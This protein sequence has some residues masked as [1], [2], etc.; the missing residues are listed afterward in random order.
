MIEEI[1]KLR[2]KGLSFRKIAKELDSTVG[3]VQ[4]QWKKYSE[5]DTELLNHNNTIKV[6]GDNDI[7]HQVGRRFTQKLPGIKKDDLV[8][9][10]LDSARLMVFW[11][12]SPHKKD[13]VSRFY[14]HPFKSYVQVLKVHDVSSII[15]NGKNAHSSQEI[16]LLNDE[17]YWMIKGLKPG[18]CYCLEMGI[19]LTEQKFLPLLRSNTIHVPRTSR[20]QVGQLTGDISNFLNSTDH[21]PNWVEHVSTYSYYENLNEKEGK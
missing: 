20:D 19:K 13:L 7:K 8:A 11:S 3:K 14:G 4:Y 5:I 21:P 18:R 17:T 15:F 12:V 16:T 1:V 10:L 9:W 6:S 2:R